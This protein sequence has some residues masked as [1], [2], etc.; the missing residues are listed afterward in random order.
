MSNS[1]DPHGQR[2]LIGYGPWDSLG[3]NT[4]VGCHFPLQGIFPTRES[5]PD[6]LQ[7]RQIFYQLSYKG[8]FACNNRQIGSYDSGSAEV[9]NPN[10]SVSLQR[11]GSLVLAHLQML[12]RQTQLWGR[13]L[14][15]HQEDLARR[16]NFGGAL[17][18]AGVNSVPLVP[19][20]SSGFLLLRQDAAFL[21]QS[22][23]VKFQELPGLTGFFSLIKHLLEG[24][25][26]PLDCHMTLAEFLSQLRTRDISEH[27]ELLLGQQDDAG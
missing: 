25:L 7:C 2:S 15:Q 14:L 6:I 8:S 10:T 21:L 12:S 1:C 17:F 3:K 20:V 24:V 27:P 23:E 22:L 4:E 9:K 16:H 18:N 26:E 19:K 5:N 13:F 11:S